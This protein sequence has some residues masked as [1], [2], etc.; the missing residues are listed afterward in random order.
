MVTPYS[1]SADG[2]LDLAKV[3]EAEASSEAQARAVFQHCMREASGT[4]RS[5]NS[6]AAVIGVLRSYSLANATLRQA[7]HWMRPS[8]RP[9]WSK[10]TA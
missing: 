6:S 10:A 1:A 3:I 7:V 9:V 4:T 8:P 5:F 2:E